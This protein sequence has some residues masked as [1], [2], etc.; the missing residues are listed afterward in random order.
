MSRQFGSLLWAWFIIAAL[1][2]VA[3]GSLFPE[4]SLILKSGV[5]EEPFGSYVAAEANVP[6]E[7]DTNFSSPL[8]SPSPPKPAPE[9]PETKTSI[10][11]APARFDYANLVSDSPEDQIQS[12]YSEDYRMN[13]RLF[14]HADGVHAHGIGCH[15]YRWQTYAGALFWNRTS[16][17][18]GTTVTANVINGN[19]PLP[20]LQSNDYDFNWHNGWEIGLQRQLSRVW[21][22]EAR[23]YRVDSFDAVGSPIFSLTGVTVEYGD[24]ISYDDPST[25]V[26]SYSSELTNLE[27]NLRRNITPRIDL[28]F[29]FRYI[30]M[31][32]RYQ[33]GIQTENEVTNDYFHSIYAFNNMYGA[34]LGPD[35][36]LWNRGP[37]YVEWGARLG[38]YGNRIN[39]GV[40]IS[41]D[42][43]LN[44]NGNDVLYQNKATQDH[45]AFSADMRL[46]ATYQYNDSLAIRFGYE[47]L[48]LEGV[49]EATAQVAGAQPAE[50][51]DG[52]AGI[53]TDG[54]PFYH[55]A[56][57]DMV[58]TW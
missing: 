28:I 7:D 11:P 3:N 58:L 41:G 30:Q 24:P 18:G 51:L 1:A 35:V 27:L 48:W 46:A 47:T 21:A 37:F 5:S 29:G 43:P 33:L 8:S 56:F 54:S 38:V 45:T 19:G 49:A 53:D 12:V 32:D 20:L 50:N 31:N 15:C 16:P 17:G 57:V 52:F 40:T 55:G 2:S 13:P 4:G 23:F 22:A 25:V 6:V 42:T 36:L 39:N 14:T 26:S 10:P 44:G 34:H 9:T